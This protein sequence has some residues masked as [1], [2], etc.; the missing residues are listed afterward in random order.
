MLGS[1]GEI[2]RNI[3]LGMPDNNIEVENMVASKDILT[4]IDLVDDGS[5]NIVM[6]TRIDVQSCMVTSYDCLVGTV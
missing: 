4:D 1:L 3:F 2:H 5:D 6:I